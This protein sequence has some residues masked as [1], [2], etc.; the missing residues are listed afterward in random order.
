MSK[1]GDS[2]EV[3]IGDLIAIGEG[4]Y[5]VVRKWKM[6][7]YH[8]WLYIIEKVAGTKI[9]FVR[10]YENSDV[11]I[12]GDRI[13]IQGGSIEQLLTYNAGAAC[14]KVDPDI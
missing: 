5:L 7:K 13:T 9:H 14:E 8:T 3:T 1:A 2:I 10:Y 11:F 6:D 12:L 4:H